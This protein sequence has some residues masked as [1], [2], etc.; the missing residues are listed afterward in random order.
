MI[1]I[2]DVIVALVFFKEPAARERIPTDRNN[3]S[4]PAFDFIFDTILID[5]MHDDA[6][7]NRSHQGDQ[8]K[9]DIH[10]AIFV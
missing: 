5:K 2:G 6:E 7:P 1:D 10:V 8:E 4:E 9:L 3:S